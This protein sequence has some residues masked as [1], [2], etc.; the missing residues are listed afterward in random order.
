M[1][2]LHGTNAPASLS[3]RT[4]PCRQ[5]VRSVTIWVH[6]RPGG[7]RKEATIC[8][9][10]RDGSAPLLVA[11]VAAVYALWVTGTAMA[12]AT[13]MVIAAVVFGLG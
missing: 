12:S 10:R 2:P 6:A 8:P 5:L 7:N 4:E 9:T 1:A 3:P 13:N 11:V